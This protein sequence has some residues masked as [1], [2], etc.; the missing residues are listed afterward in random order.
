[1]DN[2]QKHNSCIF[3]RDFALTIVAQF[4]YRVFLVLPHKY[5]DNI[6]SQTVSFHILSNY[7]FTGHPSIRPY[8]A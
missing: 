2:V 6:L 4:F 3:K 8:I 1:M 5:R 7:L